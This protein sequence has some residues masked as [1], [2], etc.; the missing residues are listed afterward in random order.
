M[1]K[2]T[3]Q[4]VRQ[5]YDRLAAG[6]ADRYFDELQSKP[7]DREV[8]TRFAAE[9][10]GNGDVCDMACGAGHIAR[11][12]RDNGTS[13]IGLDLSPGMIEQAR[14]R[15]PDIAFHVGNMMA[16]PFQDGTLAGIVAFYAIVNIP[17]DSL[18]SVFQQM[19]RVLQPRGLLLLS[20]HIG[21]EV[22][23]PNELLGVPI[24]MDFFFFQPRDI[25]RCLEAAGFSIEE[26]VEREPYAPEV[27][28]QSRRAYIFA[29][30]P[31]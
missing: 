29:R 2:N 7:F 14:Q 1:N 19:A 8:L 23:S 22:V 30:K 21:D 11:F 15:N 3:A 5:N 17:Q 9:V 27:E 4:S 26:V 20:F 25:G 31:G 10:R 12:L 28:Y 24:S 18:P 6:Y 16:L 13:V